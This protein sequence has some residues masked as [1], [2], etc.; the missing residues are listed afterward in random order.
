[1]S[2]QKKVVVE[3]GTEEIPARMLEAALSTYEKRTDDWLDENN[4]KGNFEVFGTPRRLVFDGEL[5]AVQETWTDLEKGPP[6]DVAYD[7]GEPTQA[8]EGFC[9]EHGVDPDL[10]EQR[11]DNGGD[12]IFVEVERGGTPVEDLIED[13]FAEVVTGYVWPKTMRWEA[14]RTEFIRPIR[15]VLAFCDDDPLNV[16]IGPMQSGTTTRGLR[17]SDGEEFQ[18]ESSDDYWDKIRNRT[19]IVPDQEQRLELIEKRSEELASDVG[20]NPVYDKNLM[21]EVTHLVE[22]PTPF[23]GSFDERFLEVPDPVLKESMQDHQWYFPVAG[24][25]DNLLPYFIGVRNGGEKN[26]ETVVEGNEK[27]LRARLNDAEFFYEK[28][29]ETDYKNY[30]ER[31]KGVVFQEELG[32]L[33]D[34]TERLAGLVEGIGDTDVDLSH[35][36]RHCKN[37][38]VTDMVEEFPK[39]QGTMG[40]IYARESGWD[41]DEAKII[42]A[43]YRP[44]DRGESIPERTESQVLALYD[45]VDTLVGFFA[46]GERPTGSSDPYGL[47]RDALGIIR[48]ILDGSLPEDS[49][50]IRVL[51][52]SVRERYEEDA[53]EFSD[54]VE[55]ELAE[56][57][58]ERL[59]NFA[60]ADNTSFQEAGDHSFN[61]QALEASIMN[62]WYRPDVVEQ[63]YQWITKNWIKQDPSGLQQF[64]EAYQRVDNILSAEEVPDGGPESSRFQHDVEER[65]KS[66]LEALD[67]S[68]DHA[69]SHGKGDTVL[70]ELLEIVPV[71]NDFFET[72]LVNAEDEAIRENRLRLLTEIRQTIDRV[73]DFSRISPK[74]TP[75]C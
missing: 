41:T 66:A 8:L 65:L 63:R 21:D 19:S 26:L 39:L 23:R 31:L 1:M 15:W 52:R 7:D 18:V 58:R 61:H 45:R 4:I 55:M 60:E 71:I 16:A 59:I 44:G 10:V 42:E 17:F 62:F 74:E 34:K 68:L 56:F 6:V 29:L 33:Y 47:R 20:G 22:T 69:L 2:E 73:A 37:D 40:K 14:S 28:D 30:R 53:L 3:V 57:F 27:V 43:H 11:S 51:L 36:A 25:H 48:L 67:N 13:S 9:R 24:K 64:L 5:E 72:V 75:H 12:Y 49:K 50:N 38:L 70:D 32:S 46:L 54:D 35:V